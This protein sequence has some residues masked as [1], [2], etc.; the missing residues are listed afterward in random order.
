MV[1]AACCLEDI[2]KTLDLKT[3]E[4]LNKVKR[5]ICVALEQQAKSLASRCRTALSRLSQMM[6]TADRGCSNTH[7]PQAAGSNGD[8]SGNSSD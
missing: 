6:A 2:S 8:T 5:L 1:A 7:T 3:N 4:R